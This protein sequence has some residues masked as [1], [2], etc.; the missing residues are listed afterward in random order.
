M[1]G[2]TV[3]EKTGFDKATGGT[4][5][6]DADG[7]EIQQSNIPRTI[8]ARDTKIDLKSIQVPQ[9]RIAQAMTEEVKQKKA[10]VGQFVL[11]NYPARDEIL[12]IPFDV[13]P[14]RE[15]KPDPRGAAMC[16]APTGRFGFGNPGGACVDEDD[17][18]L[19]PLAKWTSQG[20]G[21]PN[22]PPV[23]KDGL[24]MRGYSVTHRSMIDFRFM[25]A[26]KRDGNFVYQQGISFGWTAF[27]LKMTAVEKDNKKGSWYVASLEMLPDDPQNNKLEF[28]EAKSP[29]IPAEQWT[30]ALKWY[31]MFEQSKVD[32]AQEA[33]LQLSS[34]V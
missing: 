10:Q 2:R 20:E 33:V 19:C 25:G 30:V 4:A 16:H 14:V 17:N 34:T 12:L 26:S 13:A 11:T 8:F 3:S 7:E 29:N 1:K 24:V 28:D 6:V 32:S 22:K 5:P 27:G 21:M 15:Y 31:D 23:C 18:P 9:L